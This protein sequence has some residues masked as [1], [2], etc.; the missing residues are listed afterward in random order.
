M[1]AIRSYYVLTMTQKLKT[2]KITVQ[3]Q[4]N[5]VGGFRDAGINKI[6]LKNGRFM[7]AVTLTI[8]MCQKNRKYENH[9]TGVFKSAEFN[10]TSLSN[11]I[12]EVNLP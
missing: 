4:N 6:T 10:G 7:P 9:C 8:Q 12:A 1:Y 2:S 3:H 11:I 5:F